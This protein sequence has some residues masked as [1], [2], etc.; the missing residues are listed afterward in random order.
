MQ[1]GALPKLFVVPPGHK[2][3]L[4]KRQP[5]FTA[6]YKNEDEAKPLFKENKEKIFELQ[7]KFYA[8][9]TR[10]LL[11]VLQGMDTAGKDGTI[12]H[13]FGGIDPKGCEVTSFKA[14]SREER[15]HDFLW[16]IHEHIPPKGSIGIFHRSH[17]EDV[18]VPRVKNLVPENIWQA[19]YDQINDFE[20]MLTENGVLI[21]KLFLHISKDEQKQRILKRIENETKHW[22]LDENDIK[23]RKFWND[24]FGAYEDLISNCSTEWAPWYVIPGDHKWFR[25]LVISQILLDTFEAMDLKYPKPSFDV[26]TINLD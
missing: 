4:G 15:Q 19:R 23:E 13:V 2:A 12:R 16:R 3:S 6:K 26:N 10:A 17:Y 9:G 11:V 25:N 20:K 5:D 22:K 14:P 8:D 18:L 21:L 1:V 7:R 24:Y